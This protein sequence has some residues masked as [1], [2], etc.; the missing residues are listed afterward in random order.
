VRYRH[1]RRTAIAV[2][3]AMAFVLLIAVAVGRVL[4]SPRVRTG[5]TD[6]LEG[7]ARDRDLSLDIGSLTWGALPP[8][9]ILRDVEL[10]GTHFTVFVDQLE[11][12]LTRIRA[13]RRVIELETVAADG[14]RVRLEGLPRPAPRRS[15]PLFRIV[16]RHLDLR[17]I[18]LEGQDLPGNVDLA[19]DGA[20][21]V[22]TTEQGAPAGFLAAP[23][24]RLSAPG[25]EPLELSL[26]SRVVV[27]DDGVRFPGW[28]LTGEGLSLA[29]VLVA[30]TLGVLCGSLVQYTLGKYLGQDR[31]RW[32]LCRLL[33]RCGRLLARMWFRWG[34]GND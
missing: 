21:L 31:V 26:Q 22:W 15:S 7:V 19:V 4:S 5:V 27:D 33:L 18:A 11:V 2:L 8:R 32:L 24:A 6:W 29:G 20:N 28:R 13:A 1:L 17:D 9:A 10:T 3:A 14:I 23:R 25:L 12:E 16:V 34:L 30:S